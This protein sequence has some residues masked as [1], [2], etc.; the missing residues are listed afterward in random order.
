MDLTALLV[1]EA[2]LALD[3]GSFPSYIE[4]SCKQRNYSL[5]FPTIPC[6]AFTVLPHY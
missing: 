1:M 5:D 2:I 6:Q 3:T 4:F